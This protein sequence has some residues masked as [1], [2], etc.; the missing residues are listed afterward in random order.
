MCYYWCPEQN[1]GN[2]YKKNGD[3]KSNN[4]NNSIKPMKI[5]RENHDINAQNNGL[6]DENEMML[7]T[8]NKHSFN[9]W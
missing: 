5:Q 2:D 7:I 4:I 9:N 1:Q 3:I 6:K 8:K